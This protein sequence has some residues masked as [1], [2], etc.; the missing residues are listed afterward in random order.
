MRRTKTTALTIAVAAAALAAAPTAGAAT[1]VG[2]TLAPDAGCANGVTHLQANSPGSSY[3][4][5]SAGVITSW[6]YQAPASPTQVKLKVARPVGGNQFTIVGD[7]G[8]EAPVQT[9]VNTYP[10]SIRVQAGDVIGLFVASGG[11]CFETTPPPGYSFMYLAGDPAPG[12]TSTYSGPVTF[13]LDVSVTLEPDCD[14]DGLGDE[15][16]DNDIRSCPPAP[17]TTITEQPK[18]KI[19]TKKKKVSVTFAFTANE[20]GAGFECSLD[21][22]AFAHCTSPDTFQVKKGAHNFSVRATDVG[23]NVEG[24]PAS[25]DWKVK[26]KKKK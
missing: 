15:T 25:D 3:A 10:V 21:G 19:K 9:I 20:A 2:Q 16:Q 6:S 7:G 11:Y 17:E 23:G 14:D 12:T 8:L 5:P 26:K 1:Q 4:A 13:Q 22:G 18:D 24:T